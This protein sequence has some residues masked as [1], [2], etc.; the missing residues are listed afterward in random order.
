M[1][2]G[3]LLHATLDAF[4]VVGGVIAITSGV[5]AGLALMFDRDIA[6]AADMGVAIGGIWG[7]PS[8]IVLFILE[9]AHAL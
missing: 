7:A 8:A 9:L 1:T 6:N 5:L 4:A 3:L 2:A